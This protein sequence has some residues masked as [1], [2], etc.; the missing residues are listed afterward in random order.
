LDN[1]PLIVEQF[2]PY[3][4]GPKGK[5]KSAFL[6]AMRLVARSVHRIGYQIEMHN[7]RIGEDFTCIAMDWVW[8][9]VA[10]M[11]KKRVESKDM[12]Y[13]I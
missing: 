8:E 11:R 3:K 6:H 12:E 10:D 7:L 1:K 9:A 4:L 5:E 13:W 2:E